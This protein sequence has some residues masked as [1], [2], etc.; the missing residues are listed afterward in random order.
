MLLAAD[1]LITNQDAPRAF[2][3]TPQ[4]EE[5][6]TE[7]GFCNR[8]S[9]GLKRTSRKVRANHAKGPKSVHPYTRRTTEKHPVRMSQVQS[10]RHCLIALRNE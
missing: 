8:T 7:E 4:G 2:L 6:S 10:L 9:P 5:T 3:K 1:M